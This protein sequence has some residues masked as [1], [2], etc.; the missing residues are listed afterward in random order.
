VFTVT[1]NTGYSNGTLGLNLIDDDSI[2][3]A[4]NVAL[5]GNGA[6]NGSFTGEFYD[7]TRPP[8]PPKLTAIDPARLL[9][10]RSGLS[11][12]DGLF[13]AIGVRGAGSVTE[14]QI[15]GRVGVP[16]DASA[17]VLNV[18]ATNAQAAGFI[19]VFPCGTTRPTVSNLNTTA[20]GTVPN[21]VVTKIGTGGKV[22]IFTSSATDIIADINGYFPA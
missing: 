9:E 22:C 3:D 13:N 4:T 11:T 17:V 19:T 2:R 12:I 10:T 7:V 6:G 1:A 18:T 20:G 21:A 15:T 14:L 8:P 16:S 5:A